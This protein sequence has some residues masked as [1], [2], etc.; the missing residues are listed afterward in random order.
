MPTGKGEF[1]TFDVKMSGG[2]F[3]GET[4]RNVRK[5][6]VENE[7]ELGIDVVKMVQDQLR[8]VLQH[9]TGHY[10]SSIY[11]ERSELEETVTDG[12]IIYG[13]WLEGVSQR[14]EATRFKGYATFRKVAQKLQGIAYLK[15]NQA[16]SRFTRRENS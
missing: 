7:E 8:T 14:N 6:I 5:A 2:L 16:I 4:Q 10:Q 13:P 3:N 11:A 1:L 12:G 15:T 9:P